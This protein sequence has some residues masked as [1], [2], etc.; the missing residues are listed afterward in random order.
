M[1]GFFTL[2]INIKHREV[3]RKKERQEGWGALKDW[4]HGNI[5]QKA[6]WARKITSI[7]MESLK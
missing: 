3:S 5:Y 1:K 7:G 4:D 6:S 2:S